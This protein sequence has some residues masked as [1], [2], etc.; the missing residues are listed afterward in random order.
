MRKTHIFHGLIILGSLLIIVSSVFV[1]YLID[2]EEERNVISVPLSGMPADG[3]TVVGEITFDDL[4]LVPGTQCEYDVV[5][6]RDRTY[7]KGKYIF[8]LDFVEVAPSPLKEHAYVK[9]IYDDTVVCDELMTTVMESDDIVVTISFDGHKEKT[10]KIIYYLPDEVG[11]EAKN[12]GA[13]FKL[14]LTAT[15]D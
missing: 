9:I 10:L 3:E 11:N 6:A 12:A 14:V 7:S 8:S 5:L 13:Q 15:N 4:V 1:L 2:T